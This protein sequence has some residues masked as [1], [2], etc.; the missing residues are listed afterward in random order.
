MDAG[1]TMNYKFNDDPMLK[2]AFSTR[3]PTERKKVAQDFLMNCDFKACVE[4]AN[5]RIIRIIETFN[6][7]QNELEYMNNVLENYK[8]GINTNFDA[9]ISF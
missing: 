1:E 7:A 8:K 6:I 5:E 2:Y 9:F 4:R 3:N